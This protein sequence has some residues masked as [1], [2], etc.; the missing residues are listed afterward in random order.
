VL[1]QLDLRLYA[2]LDP[3][4]AGGH[5]LPDLARKLVAGGITLAQMRDKRGDPRSRIELARTLKAALGAVPLI[6]NDQIEVAIEAQADGIHLG[7]GDLDVATARARLGPVP[8][9]GLTIK[10][11]AQAWSAPLR[12]IDYV[13]IGGVF[14]TTSKINV[15]APIGLDGLRAIVRIF[16]YRIG[17]FPMCA[18]AGIDANNCAGVI[19]AGVDGVSV[20]SA[21]SHASDPVAAARALRSIVDAA[22][23]RCTPKVPAVG[24]TAHH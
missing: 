6:I 14:G 7:Q 24:A 20:I 17:N 9:I 16:R 13:G 12:E 2:I 4:N 23:A 3:E 15:D 22:L 21:L 1:D 11:P 19:E 8:F 18:I 10:T 5:T